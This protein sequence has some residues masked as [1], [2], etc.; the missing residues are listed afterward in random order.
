MATR[1]RTPFE[2]PNRT[3]AP[4]ASMR[5]TTSRASALVAAPKSAAWFRSTCG[6]P[7][8]AKNERS[9][10]NAE[11]AGPPENTI[12]AWAAYSRQSDAASG[13]SALLVTRRRVAAEDLAATHA[14]DTV[15]LRLPEDFDHVAVLDLV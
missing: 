7:E 8:G 15:S 6:A 2:H 4:A 12:A 11:G 3:G 13:D 14:P 1:S 9:V 10:T 5:S